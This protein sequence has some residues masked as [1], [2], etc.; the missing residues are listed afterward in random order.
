M[1]EVEGTAQQVSRLASTRMRILLAVIVL[2]VFVSA[3]IAVVLHRIGT[4]D[5]AHLHDDVAS[6]KG[7]FLAGTIGF[8]LFVVAISLWSQIEIKTR[9]AQVSRAA[10][11]IAAGDLHPELRLLVHDYDEVGKSAG[12]VQ[13]MLAEL[14]EIAAH[15]ERVAAGDLSGDLPPRSERDELR[16]ALAA[17]TDGL[18]AMVGDLS[19]AAETVAT[20]S[21]RVVTDAGE[22][23]RAVDEIAGAA[24]AVATGAERQVA[25]VAEVRALSTGVAGD[26]RESAARAREAAGEAGRARELAHDGATAVAAAGDA[27]QA[28][29]GASAEVTRTIRSLGERSSQIGSLVDTIGGIAEQTNLLALN[30]AIEAAR[31]GEQGRGFAVVADEVRK[32]AE[33]SQSAARSIASVIAEIQAETERA[34]AVVEDGFA[35]TEEGVVTVQAAQA[36]FAGIGEAVEA[37]SVRVAAIA[38]TVGAIASGSERVDADVGEV[39]A[40]AEASSAAAQQVAASAQQTAAS[41]REIAASAAAL[42]DSAAELRRLAARFSV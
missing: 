34:V 24:D 38:D 3:E 39:A 31:A 6:A 13:R 11:A 19:A 18:R 16:R 30:A 22:A 37:T 2:L 29:S 42:T 40:V 8:F 27:M 33:E 17:M 15:A 21:G 1:T 4:I 9:L 41:T 10:D 32:L 35:R 25:A 26:T 36:S 14:R 28:V 20:V 23:R 12:A 7:F 5:A